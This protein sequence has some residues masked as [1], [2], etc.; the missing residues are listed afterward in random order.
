MYVSYILCKRWLKVNSI[1]KDQTYKLATSWLG[2]GGVLEL[3]NTSNDQVSL[4]SN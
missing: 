3:L 1:A 2:E 4:K